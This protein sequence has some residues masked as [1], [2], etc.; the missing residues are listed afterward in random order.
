MSKKTSLTMPVYENLLAHLVDFEE[1]RSSIVNFYFPEFDKKREEFEQ[2]IDGYISALDAVVKSILLS[3]KASNSFPFVCLNSEV[4]VE[5][6]E[7]AETYNY[8]IIIPES[9]CSEDNCITILSP[10]GRALLCKKEGD[11]VS[12]NTPSGV[13]RYRIKSIKLR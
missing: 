10:M 4:E 6:I 7:E 5:D 1:R 12:V 8:K 11:V 9:N 3:D 2:L 13:Y